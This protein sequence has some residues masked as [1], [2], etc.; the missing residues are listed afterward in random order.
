LYK[1]LQKGIMLSS[2]NYCQCRITI[3]AD[4]VNPALTSCNHQQ[5]KTTL[6]LSRSARWNYEQANRWVLKIS[7]F[8]IFNRDSDR[9]VMG[10][11]N[12]YVYHCNRNCLGWHLWQ[13]LLM[14]EF[15]GSTCKVWDTTFFSSVVGI[16][17]G[18]SRAVVPSLC[19]CIVHVLRLQVIAPSIFTVQLR[20]WSWISVMIYCVVYDPCSSPH[21]TETL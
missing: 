14:E 21:L 16:P 20:H 18:S 1:F 10:R 5:W 6:W 3:L 12:F 9:S 11:I 2:L 19:S 15:I 17:F 8:C 13:N 4:S 7:A